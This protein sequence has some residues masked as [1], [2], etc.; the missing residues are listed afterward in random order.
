MIRKFAS[1]ECNAKI[2]F[3]YIMSD[4]NDAFQQYNL[5]F[6]WDIAKL[7]FATNLT[8]FN[9]TNFINFLCD[10]CDSTDLKIYETGTV[11]SNFARFGQQ[12]D[13]FTIE[14]LSK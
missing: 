1:W 9:D 11:Q 5:R 8:D 2:S 14:L 13:K 4:G 10:C 3:L 12:D 6:V 7:L